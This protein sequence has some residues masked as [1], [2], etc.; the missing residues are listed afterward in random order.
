MTNATDKAPTRCP[1][2]G[3]DQRGVMASWAE[4]CPLLGVCSECGLAIDWAEILNPRF[5]LPGWCV[6]ASAPVSR[7]PAQSLRTLIITHIPWKLWRQLKMTH[8]SNGRRLFAHLVM[9]GLVLYIAL[10][11]AT[12]MD[13]RQHLQQMLASRWGPL[14]TPGTSSITPT[15]AVLRAALL[16]FSTRSIGTYT[17][18]AGAAMNPGPIVSALPPPQQ[19]FWSVLSRLGSPLAVLVTLP[20]CCAAAFAALPI[21]RKRAKVQSRHIVRAMVY[22]YGLILPAAVLA[23]INAGWVRG[24]SVPNPFAL[25]SMV[26]WVVILTLHWMFWWMTAERYL[27]MQH[28]A[29]VATAVFLIGFLAPLSAWGLQYYWFG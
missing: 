24:S 10:S 27:R 3:Y 26:A 1:R 13:A 25:L 17:I 23:T 8:A 9:L 11:I 12:G 18:P 16:P 5:A 2:C 19:S 21:S 4:S 6:E 15:G 28:A 14:R 20:L 7:F 22:A 29:A